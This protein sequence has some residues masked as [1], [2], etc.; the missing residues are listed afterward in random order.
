MPTDPSDCANATPLTTAQVDAELGNSQ[1][2]IATNT[3]T[4]PTDF[5]PPYG[6]YN[7]NVLAQIAKYY[8]SMRQFK[9]A[10]NNANVWPY[11]DYYLQDF[12]VQEKTDPVSTVET[13]INNAIANNQWL[14]LT[15]HNIETARVRILMTTNTVPV[16][17]PK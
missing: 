17:S 14:I 5:A 12:V 1:S 3:G 15:F 10:S 2:A 4:T 9:N 16:S 13:A 6:D 11:S 8:S 7:N